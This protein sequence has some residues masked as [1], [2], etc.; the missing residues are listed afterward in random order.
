LIHSYG[1]SVILQNDEVIWFRPGG[2]R[3][4][5]GPALPPE[6]EAPEPDPPKQKPMLDL[7]ETAPLPALFHL[8][9]TDNNIVRDT[10]TRWLLKLGLR[11]SG[12]V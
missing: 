1:W 2:R 7:P 4:E 9:E 8:L 5:P 11:E 10:A 6:P 3:Y 12:L